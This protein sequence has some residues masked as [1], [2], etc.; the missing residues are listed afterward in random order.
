VLGFGVLASDIFTADY[1]VLTIAICTY[2]ILANHKHRSNWIQDHRIV[3]S[4][5]PWFLSVL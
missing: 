5:F 3:V 4:I 1:W 2:L